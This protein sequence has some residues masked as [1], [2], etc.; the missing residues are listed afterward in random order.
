MKI[1]YFF[2]TRRNRVEFIEQKALEAIKIIN[3]YNNILKQFSRGYKPD[4]NLILDQLVLIELQDKIDNY[5]TIYYKL[6]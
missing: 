4:L 5:T 3:E 6:K 1:K 2:L